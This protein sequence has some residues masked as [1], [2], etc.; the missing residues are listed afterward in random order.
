MPLKYITS[1]SSGHNLP[2]HISTNAIIK[3]K[4]LIFSM[5]GLSIPFI[6]KIYLKAKYDPDVTELIETENWE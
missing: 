2:T 5:L 4:N 1:K 3:M 6:F